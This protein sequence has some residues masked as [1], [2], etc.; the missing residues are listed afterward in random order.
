MQ[1]YATGAIVSPPDERDYP[2][3]NFLPAAAPALPDEWSFVGL[4]QA[5]RGQGRWGCCVG[6]ALAS[7]LMGYM[8]EAPVG[9]IAPDH[10]VLS[11]WDAYQGAR[12]IT[13]PTGG[14]E[15]AYPRA[16]LEYARLHGLCLETEWAY[17]PDAPGLPAWSA[18]SSRARNRLATYSAVPT[19]AASIREAM[20]WHGPC[21][22]V[23]DTAGW[24]GVDDDGYVQGDVLEGGLHAVVVVA[25]SAK[26]QAFLIRNSWGTEWGQGGYAWVPYV[27]FKPREAWVATPAKGSP[28]PIVDWLRRVAPWLGV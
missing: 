7:G 11:A 1:T 27:R 26:R 12:S 16:A 28:P 6:M 10:E 25:W 8:Q 22:V 19:N 17:R 21:L 23:L 13:M 18:A 14:V 20:Y 3:A 9:G 5:V 4:L 15:G 24:T 2:V